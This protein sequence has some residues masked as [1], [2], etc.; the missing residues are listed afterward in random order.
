MDC[1]LNIDIFFDKT[2]N[3][4]D[5]IV[6]RPNDILKR[7][8]KTYN[9]K[10]IN[11][12]K[13]NMCEDIICIKKND[14]NNRQN[15][16]DI[17]NFE[18]IKHKFCNQCIQKKKSQEIISKIEIFNKINHIIFN[19]MS[20]P[21]VYNKID[22]IILPFSRWLELNEEGLSVFHWFAWFI[23]TKIKKYQNIKPKVYAFFQKVF[24]DNTIETLFTKEQ[25]DSI[26]GLTKLNNPK[27]T[28]LYHLVRY[29]EN[30]NDIYYK[31]LYNLLVD[32]GCK[33]LSDEQLRDIKNFNTEEEQLPDNLKIHVCDITNT[34]KNIENLI[35][36]N[37]ETKYTD[38]ELTKCIDCGSL[39]DYT[40]EIPKIILYAKEKQCDFITNLLWFAYY[41][42]K[43]L[44]KV[45]DN[46]YKLTNC[47]SDLNNIHKRHSHI[48]EI[49]AN[50]LTMSC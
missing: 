17:N 24:S 26:I 27:H 19:S 15:N 8:N 31:R 41:Q 37:L 13:N 11:F 46:Y 36:Q 21:D 14:C 10:S 18:N 30:P 20:M 23:S 6:Y 1:S 28:I 22:N 48:L 44:N 33:E 12:A 16:F 32:N 2:D 38:Y 4:D 40:K 42:R 43:L 34:Y 47:H 45:F 39:I 49:Y 9:Y 35:V 29:C 50:N 3:D 25:I 7:R 5:D